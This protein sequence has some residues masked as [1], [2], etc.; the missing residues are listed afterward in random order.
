[1]T[2]LTTTIHDPKATLSKEIDNSEE[3]WNIFENRIAVYT[4]FTS[5]NMAESLEKAGFSV[6]KGSEEQVFTYRKALDLALEKASD[7]ILYV[8]LDRLIHWDLKYPKELRKVVGEIQNAEFILIGRTERAFETHPTTQRKTERIA[9][10]LGSALLN[11]DETKDILSSTWAFAPRIGEDLLEA[12]IENSSGFYCE[13]PVRAW[14]IAENK[15]YIEVEGLEWETPDKYR[16]KIKEIGYDT[17]LNNF[18][19]PEEWEER[20]NLLENIIVSLVTH[21]D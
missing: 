9:N 3:L 5:S 12:N 1:M 18:Q 19:S 15:R 2:T 21:L 13:W 4:P 16:R 8:D 10:L 14:K 7:R 20:V 17:W 11:F 6:S